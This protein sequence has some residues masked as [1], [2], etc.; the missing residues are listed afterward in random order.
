MT[1][2]GAVP[3]SRQ[4]RASQCRS[5]VLDAAA[6]GLAE[7][8]DKLGLMPH[9]DLPA[10]LEAAGLAGRGGAG[11]PAWR[12]YQA[13][14]RRTRPVVVANGAEGEP[15]SAKDATLLLRSP[16]LVLDGLIS[17]AGSVQADRAIAYVA[18]GPG[19][20]ALRTA[21]RQRSTAGLLDV[22]V[23]V[24]DAADGFLSGE[25]SAVVSALNCGA[26]AAS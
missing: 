14:G 4:R 10:L 17:L 1:M 16:N 3:G 26:A 24:V 5:P 25:E 18:P 6:A 19:A 23:E 11:F 15:A 12:K 7:H 21:V 13:L 9:A 2:T 20:T 22:A 8:L